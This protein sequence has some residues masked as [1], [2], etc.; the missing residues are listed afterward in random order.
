VEPVQDLSII[1]LRRPAS[2]S[3]A[4]IRPARTLWIVAVRYP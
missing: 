3:R 4:V 2:R 1:E